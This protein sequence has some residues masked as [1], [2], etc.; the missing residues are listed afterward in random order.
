M[1]SRDERETG[2]AAVEGWREVEDEPNGMI[3]AA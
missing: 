3:E 1:D 2:G